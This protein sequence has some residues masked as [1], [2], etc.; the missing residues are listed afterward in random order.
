MGADFLLQGL[1]DATAQ[2][3]PEPGHLC[4]ALPLQRPPGETER[5]PH[6]L[7][8]RD[9]SAALAWF[10]G[11]KVPCKAGGMDLCGAPETD[12]GELLSPQRWWWSEEVPVRAQMGT[13]TL[14][15]PG[16]GQGQD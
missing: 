2:D 5:E 9:A 16:Q 13:P 14:R 15:G 11:S 7:G 4:R 8:A 10:P 3:L 6:F 1:P 12:W